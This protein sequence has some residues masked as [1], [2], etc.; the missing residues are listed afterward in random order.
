V[1]HH[2]SKLEANLGVSLFFR[3]SR[4][5]SLTAEGQSILEASRRM[6]AAGEEALDL[7]VAHTDQPIG[8]LRMTIPA[9]IE[10]THL[11]D[12]IWD[13]AKLFPLVDIS[14]SSSDMQVDLVK[15]RFDV[16]IRLGELSDSSLKCRRI[17]DFQRVLV[18][19]PDY[20]AS[21]AP[22]K[23]IEDLK[24]CDF[25]AISILADTITILDGNRQVT[26]QPDNVRIEVDTI[27]SA[28]SA[29]LAGL[30]VQHLPTSEIKEELASGQLVR[31]LPELTLPLLG[32]YAVWPD[33]GHQ[34]LLTRRFI[35]HLL[36]LEE[37]MDSVQGV[38]F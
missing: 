38:E 32:I 10:R 29:V 37:V 23:T 11:R 8:A 35:E 14:V 34:K 25:V 28:I 26:F 3:T 21:R 18:A 19:S 24:S 7:L 12:A 1:S 30:G 5:L 13:F 16:A 17:A 15:D 20:L 33:T 9:F 4:H 2:I 22:V 36:N 6:V 31:V 27:S